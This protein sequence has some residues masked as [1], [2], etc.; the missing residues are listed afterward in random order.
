MRVLRVLSLFAGIGG[1]DRGLERAGCT[2]VGQ[3][4]IEPFCQR[5]LAARWPGVDRA[6]DVRTLG[7]TSG[8]G[9]TVQPLD[10]L[11]GGFPCQGASVAGKRRGL[12]DDRT[13]LF[14]E[15]IRVQKIVKASWALLENVPGLRSVGL[16]HDFPTVLAALAE[17]WP[18]VGWRTLDSR[19]FNVAQRRERVFFVCGPTEAGVAQVLALTEG[20]AGD[21]E[22]GGE[23]GA[24]APGATVFGTLNSGGNSGGFRTEPGEHLVS[25]ALSAGAGGSKHGSGLDGQDDFVVFDPLTAGSNPNSNMA[26]RRREDDVV[27]LVCGPLGGGNDGIGRRTEDDPNL[28]VEPFTLASRGR[29]DTH[30]LE[31][32]QDGLANAILTPNGGRGGMGVGAIATTH[33]LT[34]EGHDASEDG[35]GLGT[36]LIAFDTT[37]ITSKLN[38]N[39][40]Q[41]GDPCHPLAAGAHPPAITGSAVRRLTPLECERLQGFPDGWTC[42][43]QP[44]EAY[45]P[46]PDAAALR[47]T[48]PDSPRYRALGNA[49]TVSVVEY[50]ARRLK[51]AVDRS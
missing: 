20:G 10:L 16:G 1:F 37:Q 17:C 3:V 27:N 35:T 24:R 49:V 48:C 6:E 15:I 8:G 33:A 18:A 42:L 45:A 26:G 50:L 4:E 13:A 23:A 7:L 30:Q 43:C 31:F 44:L 38:R 41:P 21:P 39:N 46:D 22:A 36:P 9:W 29:G 40:P 5:V 47:C 19:F 51:M 34:G 28:V 14:W 32:R 11:V 2:V 25:H 12:A